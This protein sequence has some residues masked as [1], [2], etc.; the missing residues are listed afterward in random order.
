VFNLKDIP[1]NMEK[2][3]TNRQF[4]NKLWNICKFVTENALKGADEETM[5]SIGVDGPMSKEEFE[6]LS[7][8]EKYIVSK[9]H[10]LVGSVTADIEKY[11]LGAAGSKVSL[12]LSRVEIEEY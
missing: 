11:Q 4:A 2:I 5:S 9:C 10:T 1:L 8:P 6:E 12:E 3:A 7:L